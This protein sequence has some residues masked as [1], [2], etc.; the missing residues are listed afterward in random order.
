[1]KAT[2]ASCGQKMSFAQFYPG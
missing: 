2:N 1:M